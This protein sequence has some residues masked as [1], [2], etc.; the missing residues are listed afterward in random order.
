MDKELLKELQEVLERLASVLG[1]MTTDSGE[2]DDPED[3][4]GEPS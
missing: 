2:D 1:K 3:L 4:P